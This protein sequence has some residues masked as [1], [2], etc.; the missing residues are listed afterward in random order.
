MRR[1]GGALPLAGPSWTEGVV[2]EI[3]TTLQPCT[4]GTPWSQAALL[5]GHGGGGRVWLCTA[6]RGPAGWVLLGSDR[7]HPEP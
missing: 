1:E 2:P 7:A 3:S 6:P 5:T 4:R